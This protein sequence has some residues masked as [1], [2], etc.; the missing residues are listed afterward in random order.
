MYCIEGVSED[1][2]CHQLSGCHVPSA[3]LRGPSFASSWPE[4]RKG[5]PS[6]QCGESA[7]IGNSHYLPHWNSAVGRK[8]PRAR[9]IRDADRRAAGA[10]ARA[11]ARRICVYDTSTGVRTPGRKVGAWQREPQGRSE[12]QGLRELHDWRRYPYHDREHSV[13]GSAAEGSEIAPAPRNAQLAR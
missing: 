11:R 9:R 3:S 12:L 10:A 2:A 7:C 6:L 4:F 13:V 1:H 5:P 8:G